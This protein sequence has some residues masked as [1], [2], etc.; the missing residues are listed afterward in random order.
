MRRLI[1][2]AALLVPAAAA[3]AQTVVKP[4]DG[5]ACAALNVSDEVM[6]DGPLPI[7]RTRPDAAA[8]PLMTSGGPATLISTVLVA[9][10]MRPQGGFVR[11]LNFDGREG[12]AERS[13]LRPW[14]SASNPRATCQPV[15]LS[16]GKPS[17]Q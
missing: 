2:A 15:L 16:N 6:R 12:W 13:K 10:P 9:N 17:F 7:I 8:P 11:V 5:Y 4:L 1:L 3:Q 14:R